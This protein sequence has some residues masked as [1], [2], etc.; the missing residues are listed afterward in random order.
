VGGG[1]D[2]GVTKGFV[3]VGMVPWVAKAIAS[4]VGLVFNF[5]GRRYAV[6]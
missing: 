3:A 2:L 5:A 4:A 6:F 1:V